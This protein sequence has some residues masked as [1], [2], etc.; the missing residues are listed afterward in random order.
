MR[1]Y[2]FVFAVLFLLAAA[3][4]ADAQVSYEDDS[5]YNFN[6]TFYQFYNPQK[7]KN[8]QR[9]LTPFKPTQDTAD[10]VLSAL[11]ENVNVVTQYFDW[12]G[13]PLQQVM[14]QA[15]PSKKDY[16]A[17]AVY[18]KYGRVTRQYLP[19][20]QQTANTDD[21][22]Y[23]QTVLAHDSAFYRSLFP[24][25]DTFYSL[26]KFDASPLQRVLK[27]TAEGDNWTGK[28]IGKTMSQRANTVSDSVR[29]WVIDISSEDDVPSTS[30]AYQ[31]GSLLAEEVTDERGVKTIAYKNESGQLVLTKQQLSNTPA[32]G[33]AGW[34]CTYY[35]YDEMNALRMVIPPKAVEALLAVNWNLAGNSDIRT[36]LCYAYYYDSKGR[37]IMKYIPGKGKSYIAY[38]LLGRVVM[39]QDPNLR[40]TNQWAFV[41]YDGQSR[42][43]TSGLI[44]SALIKD[45]IIAQASRSS[46]YPALSGTYTITSES[47]YDDYT[48]TSG[49]PLNS[50]LVTTHI[51]STNFY[52]T[53]N[54]FPEYA[55]QVTESKRIRGA[56]T[57]SKKIILGTSNYLYSLMLYDD[58][59]RAIQVKETNYTSGTDVQTMQY[60]FAGA[61]LR[62][63]L[64]HQKS[65]ANAQTHT[66][67]TKLTYDHA[68]R[69]TYVIKNIDGKGDKTILKNVYNELGQ[70]Q[71]KRLG[72]TPGGTETSLED[73]VYEYSIRGK[74]LGVNRDFVKDVNTTN[75][76][77]YELGYEN[78]NTIISGQS[79]ANPQVNG[80]IAGVTWK[81]KGD[82]EKRKYDYTYDNANRLV[83]ADFN[84]YSGGSFNKSAGIDFSVGNL[85]Y[86]AN[87]NILTMAQKALKLN[88]SS[89]IDQMKYSYFANSNQLQQVYDTA[90]DNSSRLGD[91]KYDA[92]GKTATDYSYDMNGSVVTDQNKKISAII[93]NYLNLP[94]SIRISGKGTV[95]YVYDAAGVKIKKITV[96]STASPVKVSS[97]LYLAGGVYENDTLQFVGHEQGRIR[98]KDTSFVY[99]YFVRDHLGNVR[100]VLTQEQQTDAYPVASLETANLNSEKTF[101]G[102]LDT[103][104][105]NK[106]TVSGYPN[107]TY[108]NPNDFIQKLSGNGAKMGANML[109]KVMS[110]DKFSIRVNSWWSSGTTPGTPVSPLTDILMALNSGVAAVSGGKATAT[111][112]SSGN[113]LNP[114]ATNFLTDQ[115]YNS[116]RPKAFINWILFDEQF[117]YVSGS[118]GFEQVGSSG[119]FTEHI[120]TELPVGKNGY[121]YIYTSNETPDI[122]VFFDNLQVTHIRGPLI[123][124]T[125]YGPWGNTLVG[126]SSKAIGK[127]DNRFEYNS[128]EKQE[129]EF[130]DG[131]GL[132][133]YDYGARMYDQQLGRWHVVDPLAEVSRRWT[134]YNYAYNNPIRFIDPDGMKSKS[135]AEGNDKAAIPGVFGKD[136]GGHSYWENQWEELLTNA[137]MSAFFQV[138]FEQ[139][140]NDAGGGGGS[141]DKSIFYDLTENQSEAPN[142]GQKGAWEIK[143]KWNNEYIQKYQEFTRNFGSSEFHN[144][145]KDYDCGD[146]GFELLINFASENNLPLRFK[147]Y[148]K[149]ELKILDASSSKFTSKE[150]FLAQA[151]KDLGAIHIIDN[152]IK[153]SISNTKS[154]DLLMTKYDNNPSATGH[155]RIVYYNTKQKNGD[156]LLQWLQATLPQGPIQGYQEY[157]SKLKDKLY[158]KSPRRWNFNFFNQ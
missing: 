90:N 82:S 144:P 81:S 10:V 77:G 126:I 50:T 96:D 9:V 57:G 21:G 99:D 47:Y 136:L 39:T 55:Q 72:V 35:I 36:G 116:S 62:T 80:N 26:V 129:K 87:S 66:L 24:L 63:H 56:V 117:K 3:I 6:W 105:V 37:P 19:Y 143:N 60:S 44:T 85:A 65:G 148:D 123:E 133:W 52:T 147:Y 11:P 78:P 23:K 38:D 2:K 8:Y 155:T 13:R 58:R 121:L 64:A 29:L 79:Y 70:L 25:E 30:T 113:I 20:V 134:P 49:T 15:S 59:G 86:D 142:S 88:S 91:F 111:E 5:S 145:T 46:D 124:E 122:D 139:V 95:K 16:V 93:Y 98:R 83:S 45:S 67:L 115:T 68:G 22:K 42:P 156:Y 118:S 4:K 146:Y 73:L 48:W 110:G 43:V 151:K 34:L 101:Y 31:A 104:R 125:H 61:I 12:W 92:S 140:S 7:A 109:L 127:P 114:A 120:R 14:K 1:R 157:F 119:S 84:Q 75:W 97:T 107:D 135:F 76:F 153:I 150:D 128:K 137:F 40:Q 28:G 158:E 102:G 18:D 130:T 94:D 132:N 41:K 71:T 100:M 152:S 131:S 154:G 108:T 53:Y 103:G 106:N 54:A 74:L 51:N 17:P 33:H 27:A 138:I 149:G 112:L 89:W 141:E 32:T 69:V